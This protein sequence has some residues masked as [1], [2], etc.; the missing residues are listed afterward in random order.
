MPGVCDLPRTTELE[1]SVYQEWQECYA[2][3]GTQRVVDGLIY[4]REEYVHFDSAVGE[5]LAVMELGRPIG[6]Y[7]NSQKDFMERKRAE[8]DKVCRHKYELMEPLIRQRR[9]TKDVTQKTWALSSSCLKSKIQRDK[10]KKIATCVFYFVFFN[11]LF[12]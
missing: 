7:F 5:F 9:G 8:V 12:P 11:F 6:E 3:N 4:N 10:E 1:N 2:F